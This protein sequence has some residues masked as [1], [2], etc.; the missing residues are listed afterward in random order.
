MKNKG[1]MVLIMTM[2][3]GLCFSCKTNKTLKGPLSGESKKNY[4][5][6]VEWIGHYKG[7]LYLLGTE[8]GDTLKVDMELIIDSPDGMGLYP[9]VL[10]YDDKDV[11]HYGIE[12][13]DAEKGHY[14]ID[15]YNS[16]KIDG[17][18]RANHFVSRFS[19]M[20]SDLIFHYEKRSD[21]I[22]IQ[23]H[24]SQSQFLNE[25][26]GEIIAKDTIPKVMTYP[27]TGYQTGFLKQIK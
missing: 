15:E 20:N 21:G 13:V 6:P 16:I 2:L 24:A 19:V 8:K 18:L 22:A 9:W 3:L 10:K 14:L 27:I 5:F 25:T 23:V 1:L 11:R 12:V 17:F 4:L 26:G 7:D